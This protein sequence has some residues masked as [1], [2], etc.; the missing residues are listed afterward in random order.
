MNS[1]VA[2]VILAGGKGARIQKDLGNALPKVLQPL[3]GK[4][5]LQHLLERLRGAPVMWPP[6][7]VIGYRGEK[8]QEMLGPDFTYV[9]QKEQLGTGHAVLQT[10]ELLRGKVQDVVVL[11][12]DM[13]YL[14]ASV[15]LQLVSTH[16]TEN[17]TLT[18]ATT[19]IANFDDWHAG[20]MSYG[21]IV[22]DVNGSVIRI[23]E[24]KDATE[25]ERAIREVNTGAACYRADWLWKHLEKLQNTNAQDEYYLTD[26]LAMALAE[27]ERVET[28][29]VDP[30]VALGV[31]TAE[32]L[33][34][35]ETVEPVS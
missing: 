3:R 9:W 16:K 27:G 14:G 23:V 28:I 20:F 22:R 5:L 1:N 24:Y 4:P 10:R 31:N 2:L 26:I 29:S 21:R 15:V 11:Y 32:E 8:V 33:K 13:P 30:R 7:L 17:N 6:V 34:R 19:T 35:L 25:E 18:F 12:G